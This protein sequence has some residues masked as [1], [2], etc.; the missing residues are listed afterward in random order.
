M[1]PPAPPRARAER[2]K[3][4]RIQLA[5][6][7]LARFGTV[8][9]VIIDLTD[10]GA[11]IEHFTRLEVGR[12][13]QFRFTWQKTAIQAEAVVMSCRV[14]RFVE[15]EKGATVYQSGLSF[16]SFAESSATA[17]R[18]MVATIVA[19]SLAEQ[20]ANARGIGPIM[21][22]ATMP[23]FRSGVVASQDE[24]RGAAD[25]PASVVERGYVRC[26]LIKGR[27]DKKW[28]RTTEQPDDGFTVPASESE[29]HI[30]QL[31]QTYEKA[32]AEGRKLI[33]M[34]AKLTMQND[35][36]NPSW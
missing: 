33:H 30:D 3:K 7:L 22:T 12:H 17:L 27:W 10:S 21:D 16:A 25:V 32:D 2:R 24:E 5:S 9:S 1:V 4:Q 26:R 11:R 19:R 13:A 23:V 36:P 35:D 18:E 15:G 34:L 8:S 14:H 31:C 28:T 29:D 6:G 20:V